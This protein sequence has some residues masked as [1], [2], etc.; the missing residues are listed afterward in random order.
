MP[1]V[2]REEVLSSRR[3]LRE[4]VVI[5]SAVREA[6]VDMAAAMRQEPRLVNGVSTR[7]LVLMMPALQARALLH[8][9][10]YVG[11]EDVE[12]LSPHVFHHRVEPAP[13]IEDPMPV[14]R[15]AVAPQV[16]KLARL[17]LTR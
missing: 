1:G 8:G 9:R 5:H 17:S 6:L 12:A 11:P 3:A 14:V 10:D 2:S 16:D 7:A 4:Q 15:D 13:G